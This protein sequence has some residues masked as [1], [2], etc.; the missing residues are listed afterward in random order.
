MDRITYDALVASVEK[1]RRN[2]QLP[3]KEGSIQSD[4]CPLCE[5]F[6]PDND[7]FDRCG[8]CPVRQ[9]TGERYCMDTPWLRAA[10]ARDRVVFSESPE[11]DW[12]VAAQR[13]ADFLAALVP[14]GG[15][16]NGVAIIRCTA[17]DT[18]AGVQIGGG[19]Q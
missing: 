9:A 8:G 12:R 3:A 18:V 7:V 17:S 1:W 15:P 4:T 11:S 13:E 19:A 6:N 10:L 5:L 2:A 14:A 16:H